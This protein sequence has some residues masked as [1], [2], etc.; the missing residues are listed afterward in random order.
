MKREKMYPFKQPWLREFQILITKFIFILWS[1]IL[2]YSI[3]PYYAILE[4]LRNLQIFGKYYLFLR[5]KIFK[6]FFFLILG[7]KKLDYEKEFQGVNLRGKV[8]VI[9]GGTRGIG[10][11]VSKYLLSKNCTIITGTSN[12]AD[13]A[14]EETIKKFKNKI[15]TE[16]DD[17]QNVSDR[18]IVLPLN[19]ASLDSVVKFS[20]QIKKTNTSVDY[21]VS[22]LFVPSN[23]N[24]YYH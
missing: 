24:Y 22:F 13:D 23:F 1:A 2:I 10:L 3:G 8:C 7:Y 6:I 5:I 16:I 20:D 21:L 17:G 11:E 4:L 18:F 19:L 12:L 15:L 9:T 14:N